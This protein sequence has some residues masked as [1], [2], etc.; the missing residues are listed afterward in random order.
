MTFTVL[1]NQIIA[2]SMSI[3]HFK[4]IKNLTDPKLLKLVYQIMTSYKQ[5]RV[6][7]ACSSF[8]I[9]YLIFHKWALAG[10]C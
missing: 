1:C 4:S 6:S 2:A 8:Y 7:F 3:K 5:D 10:G 9:I